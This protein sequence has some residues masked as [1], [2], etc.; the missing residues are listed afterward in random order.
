MCVVGAVHIGYPLWTHSKV[1]VSIHTYRADGEKPNENKDTLYCLDFLNCISLILWAVFR[2]KV[3]GVVHTATGEREWSILIGKCVLPY[4][5]P[6][7]ALLEC[8]HSA[9]H[10]HSSSPSLLPRSGSVLEYLREKRN[11]DIACRTG[12]GGVN[13]SFPQ[14]TTQTEF[15]ASLWG[16]KLFTLPSSQRSISLSRITAGRPVVSGEC[17]SCVLGEISRR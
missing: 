16:K 17:K 2:N 8:C 3:W 4:C 7:V 10:H 5:H 15:A 9:L 1:A 12:G 6:N 11:Q 13:T 14:P